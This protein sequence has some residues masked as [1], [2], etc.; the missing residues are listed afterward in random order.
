MVAKITGS[1]KVGCVVTAETEYSKSGG[2]LFTNK[3]QYSA[4]RHYFTDIPSATSLKYTVPAS[5][6]NKYIRLGISGNNK[7]LYI[8]LTIVLY[9]FLLYFQVLVR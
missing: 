4:G 9:L 6:S 7:G 2:L 8:I 5:M 1:L 3:W